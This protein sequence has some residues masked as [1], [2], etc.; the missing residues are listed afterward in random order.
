MPPLIVHNP[1]TL[2]RLDD[3]PDA[4]SAAVDAAVARARAALPA[5]QALPLP[6]RQLRLRDAA[7]RIRGAAAGIA[8]LLSEEGGKPLCESQDC[9]Q[10]AAALFEAATRPAVQQPE[11]AGVV[12][13]L[14]P[15]N[16]PVM[17]LAAATAPALA[18][19]HVVLVKAPAQNPLACLQLAALLT[20]LPAG[21]LTVLTG[22]SGTGIALAGHPAV[23]RLDFTGSAAV[24]ATLA[25]AVPDR[26]LQL[27][28]GGI[29]ACIVC[30]DADLDLAVPA[31]AWERLQ[32]A[33]QT[34]TT[35]KHLYVERSIAS[36]FVERMHQLVGLLDVDDP[37]QA[38]TDIGPLISLQ[39]AH[40]VEDQVGRALREGARLILG[41]RRFRPSGLPGHFFQPTIL[42]DVPAGCVTTREEILGPVIAVTPVEGRGMALRLAVQAAPAGGVAI[43]TADTERALRDVDA[44]AVSS[45]RINDPR[46]GEAGPFAG[47]RHAGVRRALGGILAPLP[48]QRAVHVAPRLERKP[49]W[50]P[51]RAR[52]VS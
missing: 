18:A 39:A 46:L 47:L 45:V 16:F 36:A 13:V 3:V 28:P 52:G 34:G 10:A 4:D 35:I 8:R 31:I 23:D 51:Y 44:V 40:R 5:W 20:D 49:W 24:A 48:G 1:A 19:G 33:G 7:V 50:F 41:G 14:L 38:P 6:E 21:V 17:L 42:A 15:F 32:H 11:K 30:A 37:L 25:A 12:A 22:S 43:Y 2:R 9:V 26:P 27:Q 29:D